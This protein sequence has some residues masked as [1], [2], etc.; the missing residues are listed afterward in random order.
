VKL[1]AIKIPELRDFLFANIRS[2]LKLI[3]YSCCLEFA[4][5]KLK[6]E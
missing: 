5:Q 1:S 6:K 3:T 2:P 4:I